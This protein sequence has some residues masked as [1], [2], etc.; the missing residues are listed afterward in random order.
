MRTSSLFTSNYK[1]NIINLKRNIKFKK[2]ILI[3]LINNRI[4]QGRKNK[5]C[6]S[7]F[8]RPKTNW[9]KLMKL[10]N[11]NQNKSINKEGKGMKSSN[12]C[13][14]NLTNLILLRSIFKLHCRINMT[15]RPSL[16]NSMTNYWKLKTKF[17]WLKSN[18][19]TCQLSKMTRSMD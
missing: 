8:K 1:L 11:L 19:K 9:S 13:K 2:T 4:L 6:Q 16:N 17:K 18:L 12:Y 3:R 5:S 7:I 15:M 10:S 14:I